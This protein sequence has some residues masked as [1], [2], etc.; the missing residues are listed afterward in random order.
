MAPPPVPPTP[1]QSPQGDWPVGCPLSSL[2]YVLPV[3]L[4]QLGCI[5]D[6]SCICVVLSSLGIPG[7]LRLLYLSL[8]SPWLIPI[9]HFRKS[10]SNQ[11]RPGPA[12]LLCHWALWPLF[13]FASALSWTTDTLPSPSLYLAHSRSSVTAE[14]RISYKTLF[15]VNMQRGGKI[16]VFLFLAHSQICVVIHS[17]GYPVPTVCIPSAFLTLAVPTYI[18]FLLTPSHKGRSRGS[19]SQMRSQ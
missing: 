18:V 3:S 13:R 16:R 2:F 15:P 7:W 5:P 17:A 10:V 4:L 14:W 12:L 8:F 1:A 19:V 9:G 11:I 6:C